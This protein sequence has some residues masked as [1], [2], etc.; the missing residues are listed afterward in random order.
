MRII[1]W[2]FPY[3]QGFLSAKLPTE[4]FKEEGNNNMNVHDIERRKLFCTIKNCL[5]FYF[6]PICLQ[7]KLGR[8]TA[9]LTLSVYLKMKMVKYV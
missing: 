1:I 6:N 3:P 8:R 7:S 2:I 4:V 9:K 5:F